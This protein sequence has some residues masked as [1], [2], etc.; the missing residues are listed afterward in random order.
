M[1][2]NSFTCYCFCYSICVLTS[3]IQSSSSSPYTYPQSRLFSIHRHR[4]HTSDKVHRIRSISMP[5]D[6]WQQ[7]E[8][9]KNETNKKYWNRKTKENYNNNNE[10]E[11]SC[12]ERCPSVINSKA[13][14]VAHTH[15]HTHNEFFVR[16]G[17]AAEALSL[18]VLNR[19]ALNLPINQKRHPPTVHRLHH[20]ITY[21]SVFRYRIRHCA[22]VYF[23]VCVCVQAR[24]HLNFI[25]ILSHLY[26]QRPWANRWH[27][28]ATHTE[29]T[30]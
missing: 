14:Y 19:F 17:K 6:K 8:R 27:C 16:L 5:I 3:V 4:S 18:C 1:H 13:T 25:W 24:V 2:S 20:N 7:T 22:N 28:T 26:K 30:L 29:C 11:K 15:T 9:P 12:Y 10:T 21:W 23:C